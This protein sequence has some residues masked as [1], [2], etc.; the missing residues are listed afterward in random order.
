MISS[1]THNSFSGFRASIHAKKFLQIHASM[2]P[3]VSLVIL[4]VSFVIDVT[5]Q[6]VTP[7]TIIVTT[8]NAGFIV[9]SLTECHLR[10]QDIAG[11]GALVNVGNIVLANHPITGLF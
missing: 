10:H 9:A 5:F 6:T 2:L 11:A 8:L 4:E 7:S 3:E 1:R